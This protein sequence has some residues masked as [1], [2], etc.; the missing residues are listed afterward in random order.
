MM[1]CLW[2]APH[3]SQETVIQPSRSSP[4]IQHQGIPAL[5]ALAEL[6][7]RVEAILNE[8]RKRQQQL[9]QPTD[10]PVKQG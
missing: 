2:F 3:Y 10:G 1:P 8:Q 5:E 7:E 6:A 4:D 9:D